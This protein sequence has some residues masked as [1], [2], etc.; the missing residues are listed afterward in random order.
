MFNYFVIGWSIFAILLIPILLRI[1]APY[2]R[3]AREGWGTSINNTLGWVIMELPSPIC[4]LIAFFW[5]DVPKSE[6]NYFFIGCWLLHYINR[7]ILFPLRYPNKN[8]QMP[9]TI[10]L[11]AMFFN[12]V[13]GS[14]NG[15]FLGSIHPEYPSD[16]YLHWN[17]I[18]GAVMFFGGFIM[19]IKSDNILLNL[20]KPGETGYKIPTGGLYTYLSSPNYFSEIIEWFGFAIMCWSLPGLAFAIWT[21]ANLAPRA[22]TNHKWYLEKFKDY[23]KERKAL[24]PFIY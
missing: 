12:L 8:K 20:R 23:P 15:Y 6:F 16:Y 21:F 24:I 5:S 10:A 19:N 4:L 1:S 11:N 22:L 2:G 13:N 3:Y 18:L 17:F 14:I 9:L 7:S